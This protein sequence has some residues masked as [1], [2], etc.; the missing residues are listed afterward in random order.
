MPGLGTT[1]ANTSDTGLASG[2][3][4]EIGALVRTNAATGRR[5]PVTWACGNAMPCPSAV[6]ARCSRFIKWEAISDGV[7]PLRARTIQPMRANNCSMDETSA[8]NAM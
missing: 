7:G 6:E 3:I 4:I 2:V 8:F 1:S 5:N